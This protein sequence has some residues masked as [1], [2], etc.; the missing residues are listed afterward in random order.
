MERIKLSLIRTDGGTQSREKL[1]QDLVKQ[2]SQNMKDG[3][4]FPPIT[5][6]HDGSDYWL[7]DGFHR[8]FA[9]KANGGLEIDSEIRQ[10]TARDAKLHSLTC[11]NRH[12]RPLTKAEIKEG[13]IVMLKDDEWSQWGLRK[14]AKHFSTSHTTVARIKDE[15]DGKTKPTSAKTHVEKYE[16]AGQKESKGTKTEPPKKDDDQPPAAIDPLQIRIND[17]TYA[18]EIL[19]AENTMLKDKIAIGQWD[20]SEIEKIDIEDTVKELRQRIVVLEKENFNLR[21][22]RDM[23]QDRNA[24]LM[25]QVKV[26][27]AKLKKAGM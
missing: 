19:E 6:F 12:G 20:A 10:G 8:F 26:L 24:E 27:Q 25:R 7:A 3:D 1:I 5:L 11:N 14:I 9:T 23:F 15:L 22:S 2:Y 21:D 13:I 17:L 18:I 4:I 16:P